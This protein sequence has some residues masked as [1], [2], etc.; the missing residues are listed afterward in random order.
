MGYYND[1]DRDE[2]MYALKEFLKEH[3]VSELMKV[4]TDAIERK[5]EGYLD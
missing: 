3:S 2:L 1:G 5:E 4:V